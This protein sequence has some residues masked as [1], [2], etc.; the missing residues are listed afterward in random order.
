MI[1]GLDIGRRSDHSALVC[2]EGSS[3][4]KIAEFGALRF[5]RQ[6]ELMRPTLL[7]CELVCG[8]ATGLGAA[9]CEAIEDIGIPLVHVTITG[10]RSLASTGARS[11]SVGKMWLMQ[12]LREAITGR[13]ISLDPAMPMASALIAQL[14]SMLVQFS[15][16]GYRIEARSD[17]HDDLVLALSLA[18]LARD[19]HH[20]KGSREG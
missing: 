5:S 7:K 14:R 20:G 11:V 8:D 12:R 2:I 3:I 10:G 6:V 15:G 9:V 1:A 4:G 18:L 16:R 17:M 13:E 19:I